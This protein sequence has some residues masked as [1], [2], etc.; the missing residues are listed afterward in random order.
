M[1]EQKDKTAG[2]AFELFFLKISFILMMCVSESGSYVHVSRDA[3]GSQ[4]TQTS[5]ELEVQ[6]FVNC[7]TWV[8]E[9]ELRSSAKTGCAEYC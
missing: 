4:R 9:A 7:P 1:G 6:V 3:C 5:L 2:E 8:P